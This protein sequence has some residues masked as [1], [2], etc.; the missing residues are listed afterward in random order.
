[1]ISHL[2]EQT[3]NNVYIQGLQESLTARELDSAE[4]LILTHRDKILTERLAPVMQS[5]DS[6]L[7][8]QPQSQWHFGE[9]LLAGTI[10]WAIE[11]AGVKSLYICGHSFAL[12]NQPAVDVAERFADDEKS[13]DD[14]QKS[15]I[16]R[17]M[18]N[19]NQLL[20]AKQTFAGQVEQVLEIPA[21]AETIQNGN[22]KIHAL[23]FLAQAGTF[24]A[25]DPNSGEF[26][27]L[28]PSDNRI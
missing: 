22:L 28:I 24:L 23:F 5:L 14:N 20:Q 15:I 8:E 18:N 11:E 17:L 3:S 2:K 21:V 16:D 10:H 6:L 9:S 13:A 7:L 26:A 1:M 4:C 27:P 25:F 19:Q 12:S